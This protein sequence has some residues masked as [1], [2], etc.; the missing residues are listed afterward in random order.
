MISQG[1]SAKLCLFDKNKRK[2]R[3]SLIEM[4]WTLLLFCRA[5]L[6]CLCMWKDA[7]FG[8]YHSW[9]MAS[10]AVSLW[11]WST[12]IRRATRLLAVGGKWQKKSRKIEMKVDLDSLECS[13][14]KFHWYNSPIK[15]KRWYPNQRF[16]PSTESRTRNR[17]QGFFGTGSYRGFRNHPH[18]LHHRR[19]GYLTTWGS[20]ETR[21][22]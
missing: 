5:P 6:V 15:N 19:G 3:L 12:S 16:R 22:H 11:S 14:G 1:R 20:R 8:A 4:S 21:H 7:K 9:F 18:H 10:W 2:Q 17:L 13:V